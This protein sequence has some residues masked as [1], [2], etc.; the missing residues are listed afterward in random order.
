M[1]IGIN[2]VVGNEPEAY[3]A[4]IDERTKA[5]YVETISNPK[6]TLV[7]IPAIAKVSFW[8][9][10][11]ILWFFTFYDRWLMIT[12]FPSLSTTHSG[13]EVRRVFITILNLKAETLCRISHQA[14]L[15]GCRCHWCGLLL[16]LSERMIQPAILSTVASAT[17][18]LGGHGNTIGGVVIDSGQFS[19]FRILP[20]DLLPRS[21]IY[22][23]LTSH[24]EL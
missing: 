4:A 16:Y 18:W 20:L 7:D 12:V 8:F 14:N 11:G 17:K 10:I 24:R 6:F 1:N 3:A 2:W 22:P 15:H 19:L 21:E 5:V 23:S 9:S 13:W